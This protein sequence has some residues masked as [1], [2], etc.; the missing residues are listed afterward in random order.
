MSNPLT[1]AHIRKGLKKTRVSP[2]A[3]WAEQWIAK[4]RKKTKKQS[5]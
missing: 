3:L 1:I 5:A 4:Q 2:V